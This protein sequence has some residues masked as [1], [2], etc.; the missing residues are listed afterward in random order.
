MESRSWQP[1]TGH[2]LSTYMLPKSVLIPLKGL[3][4]RASMMETCSQLPGHGD[5]VRLWEED[6][7]VADVIHLGFDI[8]RKHEELDQETWLVP[9]PIG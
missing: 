3:V 6:V 8:N 5:H 2:S 7:Q 9:D 1:G 4:L